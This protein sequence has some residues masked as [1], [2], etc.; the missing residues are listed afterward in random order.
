VLTFGVTNGRFAE[1]RT[2]LAPTPAEIV[3]KS[4]ALLKR[5]E[6]PGLA[7]P[8]LGDPQILVGGGDL[9]RQRVERGIAEHR[10]TTRPVAGDH[11]VRSLPAIRLL[12]VDVMGTDGFT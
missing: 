12:V 4:A 9:F 11:S 3:G 8:G 6:G 1:S 5:N 7:Q 10:P 2:A